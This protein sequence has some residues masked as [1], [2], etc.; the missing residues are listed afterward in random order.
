MIVYHELE[1]IVKIMDCRMRTAPAG[2]ALRVH[3]YETLGSP[4]QGLSLQ[5]LVM[6]GGN[7]AGPKDNVIV[8]LCNSIRPEC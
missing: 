5:R 1:I 4:I 7:R 3:W 6:G 2:A 8:V